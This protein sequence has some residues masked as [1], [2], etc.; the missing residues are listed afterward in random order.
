MLAKGAFAVSISGDRKVANR[1][2]VIIDT[3]IVLFSTMVTKVTIDN[4]W[5]W[6]SPFHFKNGCHHAKENQAAI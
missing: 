4:K 2:R 5:E 1:S 6:V 3:D